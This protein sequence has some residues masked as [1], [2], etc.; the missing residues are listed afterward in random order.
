MH[1]LG[2]YIGVFY[3]GIHYGDISSTAGT[4]R[5][6][7]MYCHIIGRSIT[8]R[9]YYG[10]LYY[11]WGAMRNMITGMGTIGAILLLSVLWQRIISIGG[12]LGRTVTLGGHSGIVSA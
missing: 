3:T 5:G 9:G 11:Y 7:F 8:I 4:K 6:Y 2:H 12:I 1:L 10:E